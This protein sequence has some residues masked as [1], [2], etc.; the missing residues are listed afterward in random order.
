MIVER[1]K[2]IIKVPILEE[3]KFEKLYNLIA[4]AT[5][6]STP[7]M[8]KRNFSRK[9]PLQKLKLEDNK[10]KQIIDL[11]FFNNILIYVEDDD[12]SEKTKWQL[13]F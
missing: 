13:E 11:R 3:D 4:R 6:I 2:N 7:L 12:N 10:D 1:K 5:G 9:N 8:I